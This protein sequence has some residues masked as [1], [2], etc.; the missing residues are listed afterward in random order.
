VTNFREHT[1]Q[2]IEQTL[3]TFPGERVNRPSFGCRLTDLVFAPASDKLL[4]EVKNVTRLSLTK[5]LSDLVTIE[6][7]TASC[8]ESTLT[9]VITYVIRKDQSKQ[10]AEFRRAI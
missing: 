8:E 10:V 3:F 4:V 2:L 5:Y 6:D 7:V 1:R 9:V